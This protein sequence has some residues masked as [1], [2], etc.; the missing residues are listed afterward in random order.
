MQGHKDTDIAGQKDGSPC[1]GVAKYL[2]RAASAIPWAEGHIAVEVV[3]GELTLA[4]S[5]WGCRQTWKETSFC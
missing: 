2:V 4:E 3:D 1:D 5:W